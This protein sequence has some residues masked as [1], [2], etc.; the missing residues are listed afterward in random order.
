MLETIGRTFTITLMGP[1][2]KSIRA[3]GANLPDTIAITDDGVCR[4]LWALLSQAA[5]MGVLVTNT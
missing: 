3:A 5:V 2:P 1:C 4:I